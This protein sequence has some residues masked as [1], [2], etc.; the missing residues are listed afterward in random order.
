MTELTAALMYSELFAPVA[1]VVDVA[2]TRSRSQTLHLSSPRLAGICM[3][4]PSRNAAEDRS[5]R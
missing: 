5:R 4:S 3:L 2:N 1:H